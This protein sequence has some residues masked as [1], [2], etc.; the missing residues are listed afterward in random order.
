MLYADLREALKQV[1]HRWYLL[2]PIVHSV[3]I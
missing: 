1:A 2:K 3:E